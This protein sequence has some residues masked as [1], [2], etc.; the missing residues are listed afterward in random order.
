MAF[1]NILCCSYKSL[2][3][4]KLSI[5]QSAANKRVTA[6][7]D[8][9]NNINTTIFSPTSSIESS[10]QTLQNNM[11][12]IVPD[13]TTAQQSNSILQKKYDD[14]F[15]KFK[16]AITGN[17]MYRNPSQLDKLKIDV[18]MPKI[19]KADYPD[20]LYSGFTKKLNEVSGYP[21]TYLNG[22][23]DCIWDDI[24]DDLEKLLGYLPEFSLSLKLDWLSRFPDTDFNWLMKY[25]ESILNAISKLGCASSHQAAY[26]SIKDSMPDLKKDFKINNV[27]VIDSSTIS[28]ENKLNLKNAQKVTSNALNIANEKISL[29]A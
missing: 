6:V 21:S 10:I 24:K 14:G 16:S 15:K 3:D 13:F 28:S 11:N 22:V 20:L 23:V 18:P 29:F 19:N 1:S 27:A 17:N 7:E 25:I 9:V 12:N 2:I 5:L 4:G 8:H 26:Q